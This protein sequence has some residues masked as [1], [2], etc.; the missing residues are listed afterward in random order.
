[1]FVIAGLGNPG[2]KYAKTRHNAGFCVIDQLADRYGIRMDAEKW[3]GIC[4]TGMIEGQ[5]VLL[6]KPLT[7]MNLSGDCISQ[8]VNFYKID[9]TEELLVISDDITL[10]PGRIRVRRKGSAGGHNGLK[11][12]I[13]KIGSDQ[14]MRVRVGVGEKPDGWDLADHVLGRFE[15]EDAKKVEEAFEH[16]ADAIALMICGEMDQAMNRFN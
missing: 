12:I 15:K 4:G 13:A 10:A 16:A 8:I 7:Y 5:K 3:N 9:V 6:V 2:L 11:D 1:M 14:F